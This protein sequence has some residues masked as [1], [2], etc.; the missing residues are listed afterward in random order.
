MGFICFQFVVSFLKF[1]TVVVD[2]VHLLSF[3]GQLSYVSHCG[4][5]WFICILFVISFLMVPTVA[6]DVVHLLSIC[7]QLS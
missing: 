4:W 5:M 2:G 1:P 3:C 6:V 7:G